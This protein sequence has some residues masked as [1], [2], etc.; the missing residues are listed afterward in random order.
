[1]S[2]KKFKEKIGRWLLFGSK[3]HKEPTEEAAVTFAEDVVNEPKPNFSSSVHVT[4]ENEEACPQLSQQDLLQLKEKLHAQLDQARAEW[5]QAQEEIKTELEARDKT[6]VDAESPEFVL[7]VENA[8]LPPERGFIPFTE[9]SVEGNGLL[10]WMEED[11][12]FLFLEREEA[13]VSNTLRQIIPYIVLRTGNRYWVYERGKSGGEQRLHSR[14]SLGWG[15]HVNPRDCITGT[16]GAIY[17][18]DTL[19]CCALREVREELG[20]EDFY[21]KNQTWL[22]AL[23]SDASEVEKVHL[24]WVELWETSTLLNM[25]ENMNVEGCMENIQFLTLTELRRRRDEFEGWS[26]LVIDNLRSKQ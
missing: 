18:Y 16:D 8:T 13:E 7:C 15:G 20:Y 2:W 25:Q 24:G 11:D 5:D 3:R 22:G 10:H 26:Q 1:M 23:V 6:S 21:P 9:E 17:V 4:D 14:L 19:A 12:Q